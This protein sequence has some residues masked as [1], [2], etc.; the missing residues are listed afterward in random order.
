MIT[1]LNIINVHK[2]LSE[3]YSFKSKLSESGQKSISCSIVENAYKIA[4]SYYMFIR[5]CLSRERD[6]FGEAQSYL[7]DKD[8]LLY[9]PRLEH[10]L[11]CLVTSLLKAIPLID[12]DKL[13]N[14][15]PE[16]A[17]EDE[18]ILKEA[19]LS[20]NKKIEVLDQLLGLPCFARKKPEEESS[21]LD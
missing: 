17:E 10:E 1:R 20:L 16:I 18:A 7:S 8:T 12:I 6:I 14:Q 9:S 4:S 3:F 2:N 5:E 13:I 11:T 21:N 19:Y 15:D